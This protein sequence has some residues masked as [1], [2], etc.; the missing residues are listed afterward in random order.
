MDAEIDEANAELENLEA[1]V[2]ETQAAL[3]QSE[4]MAAEELDILEKE[5]DEFKKSVDLKLEACE[6]KLDTAEATLS[7]LKTEEPSD[8]S[9]ADARKKA[10]EEERD[11]LISRESHMRDEVHNLTQQLSRQR[12]FLEESNKLTSKADILESEVQ[13][14]KKETEEIAVNSKKLKAAWERDEQIIFVLQERKEQLHIKGDDMGMLSQQLNRNLERLEGQ[15]VWMEECCHQAATERSHWEQRC[16]AAMETCL[17][18]EDKYKQSVDE[19]N[20]ERHELT[21]QMKRSELNIVTEHRMLEDAVQNSTL[22]VLQEKRKLE[23][24]SHSAELAACEVRAELE[25]AIAKGEGLEADF[26]QQQARAEQS[27]E[28][29]HKRAERAQ[30]I[31]TEELGALEVEE[32]EAMNDEKYWHDKAVNA[33]RV[34]H[35][36]QENLQGAEKLS[37]ELEVQKEQ[38]SVGRLRVELE[39]VEASKLQAQ[40]KAELRTVHREISSCQRETYH[41]KNY[42]KDSKKA[43]RLRDADGD[44]L[45]F[46]VHASAG[47][48]QAPL[49]AKSAQAIVDT[50]ELE[51]QVDALLRVRHMERSYGQQSRAQA[52]SSYGQQSKAQTSSAQHQSGQA[53]LPAESESPRSGSSH[54]SSRIS[55]SAKQLS[56]PRPSASAGQQSQSRVSA[57]AGQPSQARLSASSGQPFQPVREAQRSSLP[58]SMAASIPD[59]QRRHTVQQAQRRPSEGSIP[60]P[61]ALQ[62]DAHSGPRPASPADKPRR[63]SEIHQVG[64][65]EAIE[66]GSGAVMQQRG[67]VMRRQTRTELTYRC[68]DGPG[69]PQPTNVGVMAGVAP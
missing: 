27:R 37:S 12:G 20:E 49:D 10:Y 15:F 19:W 22:R 31:L 51:A 6:E 44:F 57:S 54:A 69:P 14:S 7:K 35:G 64:E 4:E 59:A 58:V 32:R 5:H 25:L 55:V 8:S 28:A 26:A 34:L 29:E 67:S 53:A 65:E 47:S 39:L 30:G 23:D 13:K 36:T 61:A 48:F 38:Q 21:G 1:E 46:A 68:S 50:T 40:L 33:A 41:M 9:G 11:A 45:D 43:A 16:E 42:L 56:Q 63:A 24:G 3:E 62:D 60:L 18:S 2:Q 17:Q 52:S 66:E